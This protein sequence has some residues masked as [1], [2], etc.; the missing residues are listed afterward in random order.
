MK[1]GEFMPENAASE[2][3]S[4]SKTFLNYKIDTI[5]GKTYA[6]AR[7]FVKNGMVWI[8]SPHLQRK[9]EGNTFEPLK[10]FRLGIPLQR[11]E[12]IRQEKR[13]ERE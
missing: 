5:D 10:V 1:R 7:I 4:E 13:G 8:L 9:A 12:Q 3:R 2:N 11:I 6:G